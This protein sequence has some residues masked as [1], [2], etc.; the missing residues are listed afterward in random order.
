METN[1][2]NIKLAQSD[3]QSCGFHVY[4]FIIFFWTIRQKFQSIVFGRMKKS[5]FLLSL[6][7]HKTV[8]FV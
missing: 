7:I 4:L 3:G 2:I 8:V 5:L 1:T 6:S